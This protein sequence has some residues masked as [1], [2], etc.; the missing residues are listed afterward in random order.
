MTT[1]DGAPEAFVA[2]AC[3]KTR[4]DIERFRH[5][6]DRWRRD[7]SGKPV[8]EALVEARMSQFLRYTLEMEQ[9]WVRAEGRHAG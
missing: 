8:D 9:T 1:H 2:E 6:V 5:E 3:A 7:H 4:A